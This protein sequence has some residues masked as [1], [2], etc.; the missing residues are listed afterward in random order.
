M[1]TDNVEGFRPDTIKL[2]RDLNSAMYRLPGG[3]SLS[4][5]DWHDAI[6]DIDKRPP[7]FDYAFRAM[8]PNDVGIDEFMTMCKLLNVEPYVTVNAG[9]G[10]A[11]SAAE[12]VEYLNGSTSTRMGALRASNGHPEPYNVKYWNI[13]NEMYGYWQI[14]HTYLRYYALKHNFFAKAMRKADPSITILACGAMPDEMTVTGN[15][16]LATGKTQAEYGTEGD[17]TGGLLA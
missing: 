4:D 14:G 17:W 9:F 3:N 11:R 6:G 8:Q 1:P 2:L 16:R 12:Q 15:A 7:T 13:G 5:H 10:D